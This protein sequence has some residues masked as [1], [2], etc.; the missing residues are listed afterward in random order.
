MDIW[1]P[2]NSGLEMFNKLAYNIYKENCS[3]INL[4]VLVKSKSNFGWKI[5][6]DYKS[7]SKKCDFKTD[8]KIDRNRI[9]EKFGINS[10]KIA[11]MYMKK[12]TK[13]DQKV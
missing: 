8:K 10:T 9:K 3:K 5:K 4:D 2:E 7:N 6:I 12:L 11:H 13:I 1:L